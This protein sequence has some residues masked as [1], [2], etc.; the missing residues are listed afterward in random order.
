MLTNFHN[1]IG[2]LYGPIMPDWIYIYNPFGTILFAV[3]SILYDNSQAICLTMLVFNSKKIKARG[4][5]SLD[6]I[7]S[8]KKMVVTSMTILVFDWSTFVLFAGVMGSNVQTSSN[9]GNPVYSVTE[10]S[11]CLHGCCAVFIIQ[12]LKDLTFSDKRKPVIIAPVDFK[13]TLIEG[14]EVSTMSMQ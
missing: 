5:L 6:T 14:R 3:S 7:K 12:M 8:L 4:N 2:L 9:P 13:D 11:T 1:I 10:L